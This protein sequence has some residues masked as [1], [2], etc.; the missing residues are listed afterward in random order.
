M[1]LLQQLRGRGGLGSQQVPAAQ[2]AWAG[3][4]PAAK[5]NKTTVGQRKSR[6]SKH[7]KCWGKRELWQSVTHQEELEVKRVSSPC[8]ITGK[9]EELSTVSKLNE[10]GRCSLP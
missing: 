5:A 6:S 10:K 7:K 2:K 3:S 4:H 8:W 9:E 1:R